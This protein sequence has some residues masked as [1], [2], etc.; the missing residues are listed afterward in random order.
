MLEQLS[1]LVQVM[2]AY[3]FGVLMLVLLVWLAT[4]GKR[5]E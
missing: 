1:V 3:P 5:S 2:Q 4:R